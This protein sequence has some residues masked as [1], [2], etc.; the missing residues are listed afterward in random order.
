MS[1][2][3]RTIATDEDR[4]PRPSCEQDAPFPWRRGRL[5]TLL[6]KALCAPGLRSEWLLGPGGP[7]RPSLARWHSS[8]GR[9]RSRRGA[10]G[11]ISVTMSARRAG[12]RAR[13]TTRLK[14]RLSLLALATMVAAA[15]S[16]VL[17]G[18]LAWAGVVAVELVLIAGLVL[19]HRIAAPVVERWGRG[20]A[21]SRD[22]RLADDARRR[23]GPR[24]HRHHRGRTRR[25]VHDRGQVA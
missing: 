23:Y 15:I 7:C 11:S 6:D 3:L 4:E 21:G 13:E 12:Q 16:I 1:S 2:R 8:G 24:E 20:A 17:W 10:Y 22:R 14:A 19:L 25:P 9:A 5:L 18:N